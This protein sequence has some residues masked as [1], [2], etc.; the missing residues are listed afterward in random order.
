[1]FLLKSASCIVV[2]VL[3]TAGVAVGQ[4]PAHKAPQ[5]RDK[6]T[7]TVEGVNPT[8][9]KPES[10][11]P[12]KSAAVREKEFLKEAAIG[13]AFE[14]QAGQLAEQNA[15]SEQVKAFAKR[16]VTDHSK[17][18][19]LLK[20][21]AQTEHVALPSQLDAKH[22]NQKDALSKKKGSEFDKEYMSLMVHD[23][24]QTVQK[25]KHEADTGNDPTITK[26]AQGALPVLESHL[27]DAKTTEGQL[28]KPAKQKS[29]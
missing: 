7:K 19:D 1:M 17:N 12:I 14:I 18:D 27:N 16:M 11:K 15:G 10:N 5:H 2:A 21:V 23:H 26:Y 13:D 6:N 20:G 4:E 9:T 25:F 8:A 3:L 22:Q 24:E 29:K 28:G